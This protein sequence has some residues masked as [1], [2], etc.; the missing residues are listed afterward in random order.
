MMR[1]LLVLTALSAVSVSASCAEPP[2][3]MTEKP[4]PA[5]GYLGVLTGPIDS[6]EREGYGLKDGQAG[7]VI[8]G[9]AR[10]GPAAQAGL[11]EGD[12]LLS[13]GGMAF[14]DFEKLTAYIRGLAPGRSVAADFLRD[15][16]PRSCPVTIGA[17]PAAE[18]DP[19]KEAER[20]EARKQREEMMAM[21]PEPARVKAGELQKLY[22][23][24]G[25]PL[26]AKYLGQGLP[27]EEAHQRVQED[28]MEDPKFMKLQQEIEQIARQGG[29][30]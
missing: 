7:L 12:V 15:K 1:D 30:R 14:D 27:P 5:G 25:R 21:L 6:G 3:D 19:E 18:T 2:R 26:L 13:L 10:G 17:A 23:K 29:M 4:A 22:D 16:K 8:L 11:K 20:E 24:K 28:M 9:I